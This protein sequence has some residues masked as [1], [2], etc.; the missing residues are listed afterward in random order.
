MFEKASRLQDPE[1]MI[2][3]PLLVV[4]SLGRNSFFTFKIDILLHCSYKIYHFWCL[5][6]IT[7][8]NRVNKAKKMF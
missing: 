6:A 2:S 3:L 4:L 5:L 8:Y 7:R 1:N